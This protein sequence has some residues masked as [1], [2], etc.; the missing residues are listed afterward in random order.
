MATIRCFYTCERC[1]LDRRF[2]EVPKPEAN[3]GSVQ[4][5]QNVCIPELLKDHSKRSP[6]CTTNEFA[7]VGIPT[8]G[9]VGAGPAN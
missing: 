4:W 2:V 5:L 6:Q 7:E 3:Q 8:M 9:F 1:G